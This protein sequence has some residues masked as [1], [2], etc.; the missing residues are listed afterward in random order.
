VPLTESVS[1]AHH[2]QLCRALGDHFGAKDSKIADNDLLRPP[3]TL[4]HKPTVMD[5]GGRPPALVRWL[6]RPTGDRIDPH[7]LADLLGIEL[8]DLDT[9]ARTIGPV[10]DDEAEAV[11]D[12]PL[13]YLSL[14]AVLENSTGDRSA[15]TMRITKACRTNGLTLAETRWVINQREDLRERL[16]ERNDDDVARC[17]ERAEVQ[18]DDRTEDAPALVYTDVSAML[19]GTLPEPPKPEILTRT[20]GKSMFFVIRTARPQW[21]WQPLEVQRFRRSTGGQGASFTYDAFLGYNHQ[22]GAVRRP[23]Q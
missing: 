13:R 5:S 23:Q 16:D 17:Y 11:P 2:R 8:D 15:D 18:G 10:C 3:G 9:S 21:C 14:H 7:K 22:D 20:D 1:F 6:V 4:N 12:L 19:N